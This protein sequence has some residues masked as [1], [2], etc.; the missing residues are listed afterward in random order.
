MSTHSLILKIASCIIGVYFVY[1]GIKIFSLVK[2]ER[3]KMREGLSGEKKVS[4]LQR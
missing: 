4:V 3:K 2:E 1:G